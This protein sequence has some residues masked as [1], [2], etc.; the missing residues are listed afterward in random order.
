M[1]IKEEYLGQVI[2]I[3]GVKFDS[4]KVKE[5]EYELYSKIGFD[6]I[7]EKKPSKKIYYTNDTETPILEDN[8]PEVIKKTY[9]RKK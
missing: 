8:A 9:K 5:E 6:F 2:T 7:F 3:N 4:L 1:K